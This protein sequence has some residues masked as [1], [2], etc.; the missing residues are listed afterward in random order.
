MKVVLV[1]VERGFIS[2]WKTTPP[3]DDPR[4]IA[5]ELWGTVRSTRRVLRSSQTLSVCHLI[6][7][8]VS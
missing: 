7:V 6:S 2:G 5:T 8:N 3:L 4:G 1:E